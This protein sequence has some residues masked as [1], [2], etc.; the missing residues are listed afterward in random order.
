[1]IINVKLKEEAN[2]LDEVVVTAY[3]GTQKRAKVTSS[4]ASV[5]AE[6]L[7][8]GSF[9]NPAQALSGAV[10]GL[11]VSQTSGKP[12]ATPTLV[13]RG[14]TNLDGSGSPL[15][16]IDGQI[17]GGLNDINPDDIETMDV[18][19]DAGA[20]AIYGARASNGVVLITT[21]KGKVGTSQ[22]SVRLKHGYA[23]MNN[24]VEFLGARDYL[25]WQR[26]AYKAAAEIWQDAAGK[27]KGWANINALN[28]PTPFGTGN[29][30][31][32]S[33]TN[34]TLIDANKVAGA[35]WSP[36]LLSSL[37]PEQQQILLSQGWETM[38]DPVTGND[39]IFKEFNLS[40]NGFR[41]FAL[42][43]D[44]TFSASGGNEK[45]K[46]YA[47]LGYYTQEGLPIGS[48]YKRLTGTLN[49]DYKL[50][51]WL[52]SISNFS[53]AY[54]TWYDNMNGTN[55]VAY[56]GRML[57]APPTQKERTVNGEYT[58]GRGLGDGNPRAFEGKLL[59]DNSSNKINFGQSFKAEILKGLSFTL[60]GQIMFDESYYES[61]NK[62]YHRTVGNT[63]NDFYTSR[64]SYA[65]FGRTLRQTYNGILNYN[66][67]IG[68]HNID[69]MVGYE[70]YDSFTRG[71]NA[72]GKE[73]PT[74]DFQD[75]ALT[76]T[77]E[78]KRNIDSWHYG[79]RIKSYFGRLNYDYADKYLLSFTIRRDGYSRLLNNRWGNF[80]GASAGWVI[81]REDFI[82]ES[83]K[84]IVS[85]AKL[86]TSFGLNGNVPDKYI[87]DYTLQ[88]SYVTNKYA[89]NVGFA[90]GTFANKALRW[91][92]TRTFEIGL[93]LGFLN[94]R[95][96]TNF[97]LYDRLT[98][99]K[100]QAMYI[101]HSSGASSFNSNNGAF[102]NRGLEIETNF[103][104]LD[105]NNLR[106]DLAINTA[107][108][109]NK[110]IKL[111]SNNLD[112]NRQN[113][114]QVYD[115]TNKNEDGSSKLIWVGG[116][117]E[118]QRPGDMYAYE[119]LGIY[120]T[121][122]DV[123][124]L[125]NNLVDE[126]GAKKLYGPAAW[127][128]LTDA[129]KAN[130]FPIQPGD[131]IWRDVNQDGKIDAY[132][133][134]KI[135]NM[136]PKWTGGISTTLSYEKLRFSVR[137]DYALDFKQRIAQ[138][139]SLIWYLGDMQGEFNTV[140][141]V[142][143]TWTPENPNARFP[144]YYF[145]DQNGKRN[146][147]RNS[148]MFMYEGS[149]LAFREVALSYTLDKDIVGKF[150]LDNLELSVVGQN[151]GY[152]TKAETYSP[153]ALGDSNNAYPLPRTI[154]LGLNLTF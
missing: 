132:D 142:K 20:T 47:G 141:Q 72:S 119:A 99:D 6:T 76:S 81:T 135:G 30:H 31:F 109:I 120:R 140:Q 35:T 93:D 61:F 63:A 136:N 114:F 151:L 53:I 137:L 54:A 8:T 124:R 121:Q 130:G 153:E 19:K 41:P 15:I 22:L 27:W 2:T 115:G 103:R 83:V 3:G 44:Y 52:T 59:R 4:I 123:V 149:Y 23:Y 150:G 68:S 13:L 118:G 117:Q 104:I 29:K 5:K 45:G 33:Q 14:G 144:R 82:P 32:V 107:Y 125:A 21:K 100:I 139:N 145:A 55:D 74:D 110:V 101:P 71:L 92:K 62:D 95:I 36:M 69:A 65:S 46:Y 75:L 134:V 154:V 88:G 43:R 91:E 87:G 51:D 90:I 122:E 129:Q 58:V 80:P 108:G 34:N 112:N 42:T 78:G 38:K 85:F 84:E 106:W 111:P 131:V 39:I 9:S 152:W 96:N 50:K 25:Y 116:Y 133:Q 10:A 7:S 12:G 48:W 113:A 94:N 127:A 11:R 70:Y 77:G 146:Y 138:A 57:S 73:A 18:L 98:E 128:A 40:K 16:I 143:D 1:M 64:E 126:M 26:S 79:N 97:T 86:R 148:S 60:S 49:A 89:G 28:N 67:E 66:V 102:Q 37:S 24:Q 17:R 105:K 56:F 147:A